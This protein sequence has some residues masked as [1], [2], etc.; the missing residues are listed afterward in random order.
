MIEIIRIS[1]DNCIYIEPEDIL[2]YII[3]CSLT[4]VIITAVLHLRAN[5]HAY[6]ELFARTHVQITFHDIVDIM[7]CQLMPLLETIHLTLVK[8][9]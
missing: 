4:V 7:L 3:V 6:A 1:F 8:L 2:I 5:A 9:E